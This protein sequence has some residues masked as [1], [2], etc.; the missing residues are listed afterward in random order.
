MIEFIE[1]VR[2]NNEQTL[3]QG[4]DVDSRWLERPAEQLIAYRTRARGKAQADKEP[5]ELAAAVQED[6][7]ELNAPRIEQQQ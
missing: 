5:E 4:C 6:N 3:H 1:L 2:S 7:A